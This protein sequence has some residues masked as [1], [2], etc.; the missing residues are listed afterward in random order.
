MI[1]RLLILCCIAV[2]T[3]SGVWAEEESIVF[4]YPVWD[5]IRL[6]TRI[7]QYIVEKGYGFPTSTMSGS[8]NDVFASVRAGE[9]DIMMEAWLPNLSEPWEV[10]AMSGDVAS[11]GESLSRLSQ[12][13]YM[14]PSYLQEAHPELDSVEDLKEAQYQS[15]FAT[16][17]SEGKARLLSCPEV[18]ACN[19]VNKEQARGYGLADHVMLA[20]PESEAV[21]YKSLFDAYDKGEAWLGYLDSVMLPSLKLDMT[22]LAEPPYSDEC[23]ASDKACAYGETALLIVAPLDFVMRAP[24][25]ATMLRHWD[26]TSDLYT[27]LALWRHDNEASYSESAFWWLDEHEDVWSAWVT[28]EAAA[29]IRDALDRGEAAAGWS[30]Q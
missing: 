8:A 6:Q 7:A 17:D 14:I 11:L 19:G 15:L 1:G 29:S 30:D 26:M 25:V 23:W 10:A 13:A 4:G 9:T 28:E 24:A 3:A 27:E 12:S 2:L 21:L 5:T 18:W 16:A 20:A 22:Q